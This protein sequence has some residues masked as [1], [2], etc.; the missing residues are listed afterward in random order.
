[1]ISSQSLHFCPWPQLEIALIFRSEWLVLYSY[2][3][4]R[5]LPL[6]PPPSPLF[7]TLISPKLTPRPL[8]VS[9]VPG[10]GFSNR[11]PLHLCSLTVVC[12]LNEVMRRRSQK[13]VATADV[14]GYTACVFFWKFY[15]FLRSGLW[16]ILSR[17]LRVMRDSGLVSFL[18]CG[19]L[20]FQTPLNAHQQMTG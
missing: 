9:C 13:V 4:G 1:M 7:S 6:S 5:P 17:F 10:L 18:S 12:L 20:V 2:S 15:G 11:S 3:E 14:K 8:Q 16:S 19:S